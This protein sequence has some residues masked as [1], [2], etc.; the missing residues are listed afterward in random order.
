[1]Y[2][3]IGADQKEY[4]PVSAQEIRQW[5]IEGR[6][7]GQ[8][9][10]QAEGATN[11]QPLSAHPEFADVLN[12]APIPSFLQPTRSRSL[13]D[14]LAGD[15]QVDIGSCL[16]RSWELL[17]KNFWP[18][19]GITALVLIAAGGINQIL[20]LFSRTAMQDLMRGEVSGLRIFMV[21]ITMIL[22]MP[23]YSL[24]YGGLYLYYLKLI[25]GEP[26][27]IGDAFSGFTIAPVQLALVG[28]ATGILVLIGCLACLI[29]GIYLGI[30][31]AFAMPLVMDK[32]LGFWQAMELSR[33]VVTKHWFMILG[34]M[35]LVG[36]VSAAGIIAC[37]IGIFVTFPIGYIALMYAY[38]DI[39]GTS[40]PQNH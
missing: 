38:D 16:T 25:R 36:L 33:K 24:F 26:A 11:W 13:D 14:V 1:M 35:L 32:Q 18:V 20:G 5:I 15:Y 3:I 29:P 10:V 30:A 2:K 22:G 40:K 7:N 8:T 6:A 12:A 23:V 19:V 39:F 17:K 37:C 34:L 31:W 21:S 4:G 9:L 28:L 27:T